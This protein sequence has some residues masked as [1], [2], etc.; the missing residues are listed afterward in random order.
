MA[1]EYYVVGDDKSLAD[2]Y[3][4]ND[5]YNKDE[6]DAKFDAIDVDAKI[7]QLDLD[8]RFGKIQQDIGTKANQSDVDS[9]SSRVDS[10]IDSNH[11]SSALSGYVPTSRKINTQYLSSDVTLTY[12]DV[13]AA[14][15]THTHSDKAS[16]IVSTYTNKDQATAI[17]L[18]SMDTGSWLVFDCRTTVTDGGSNHISDRRSIKLPGNS[19]ERYML[20]TSHS[21]QDSVHED[22][23][24]GVY[25]GGTTFD[26]SYWD[27]TYTMYT[28]ATYLNGVLL[29]LA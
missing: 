29:R 11:L 23:A 20:I 2:A 18:P 21:T 26:N 17:T 15:A 22:I 12:R 3:K 7:E 28:G 10:K 16:L 27:G 8:G 1:A 13:G 5:L 19:N 14:S 9:L 4:K 25:Q 24:S 6:I